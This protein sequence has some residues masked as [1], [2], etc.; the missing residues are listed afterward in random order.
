VLRVRGTIQ[1]IVAGMITSDDCVTNAGR[2][3]IRAQPQG[4]ST[5]DWVES[6]HNLFYQATYQ[7][8]LRARDSVVQ[9]SSSASHI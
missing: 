2:T 6:S 3:V 1:Q 4:I 5:S 7:Q 8:S 9:K